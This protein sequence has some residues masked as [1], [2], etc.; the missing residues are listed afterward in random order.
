MLEDLNQKPKGGPHTDHT[1]FPCVKDLLLLFQPTPNT[2]SQ[3]YFILH[4]IIIFYHLI[5]WGRG[6]QVAS[7]Y[8]QVQK[9]G[10]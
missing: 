3:E 10:G 2:W 1:I 9:V 7:H 4:S 5:A 6:L 8:Y